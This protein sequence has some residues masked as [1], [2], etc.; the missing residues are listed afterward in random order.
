M[1]RRV[2]VFAVI[3]IAVVAAAI[4]YGVRERNRTAGEPSSRGATLPEGPLLLFRNTEIG[5]DYGLVA[6]VPLD[7]PGGERTVTD[8]AC[9]RID[10]VPTGA[11]CLVT[12]RGVLT[13]YSWLDLDADLK[14]TGSTALP[15]IPSRTR[16]SPDGRLRAATVFVTGHEYMSHG[17]STLTQIRDLDGTDY[18]DLEKFTFILDGE[19]AA[20][21]DRNVWGVTFADDDTFYATVATGGTPYLVKGDLSERTLTAIR[22]GAECPSLSPDGTKIAYKVVTHRGTPPQW[23]IAVL[24][25]ASGQETRLEGET[26]SVDDQV[27]W[28]DD[29][30]VIYGLP[31]PDQ[32][33]ASDV[34]TLPI[35]GGESPEL[36]VE[37]AWSPTVRH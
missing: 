22:E 20:P 23:G 6:A 34:W 30:T 5:P 21:A 3:A 4:G 37:N 7:D 26:R 8:L 32:P 10:A 12:E 14:V 18:G 2:L 27:A 28:L 33:G 19:P 25:L 31:R 9:D 13:K 1:S 16:V 29:D 15:G 11:S 17:F 36:L 35:H 24:D